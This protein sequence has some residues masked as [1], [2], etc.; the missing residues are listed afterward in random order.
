MDVLYLSIRCPAASEGAKFIHYHRISPT[1]HS[2]L[3]PFG[4]LFLVV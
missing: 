4:G 3:T 2:F 1:K